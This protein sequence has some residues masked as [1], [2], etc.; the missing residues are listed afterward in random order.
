MA[1]PAATLVA[2]Q[3]RGPFMTEV[4]LSRMEDSREFI[5]VSARHGIEARYAD[6]DTW[7]GDEV[8]VHRETYERA[9]RLR[10]V[11]RQFWIAEGVS[12]S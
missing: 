7:P 2:R 11:I 6:N 1:R 8:W 4:V 3:K 10:E 12:P 9:E 5:L